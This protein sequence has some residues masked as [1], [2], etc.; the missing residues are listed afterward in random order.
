MSSHVTGEGDESHRGVA[1][2]TMFRPPDVPTIDVEEAA[3]RIAGG[4]LLI[5]VREQ[6]EWD[7]ARV[8]GAVHKPIGLINDWWQDLPSDRDIVVLCR[9]GSRSAQVVNALTAQA[10]MNNVWNL[11]GGIVAWAKA[12]QPVS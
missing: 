2:R 9:S 4:A 12:G 5:D 7:E 6:D 8:P 1:W 3:R 11:A 10:G